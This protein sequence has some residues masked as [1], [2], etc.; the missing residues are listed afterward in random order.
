M[1]TTKAALIALTTARE[2]VIARL[3]DA[4]AAD[5]LDLDEFER[6]L[7]LAHRAEDVAA[8]DALVADL[9][10]P[11]PAAAPGGA[12]QAL[13]PAAP[14][15]GALVPAA[16]VRP[17]QKMLALLGSVERRGPWRVARDLT[18]RSWM[19]SVVLDFREAELGPG[20]TCVHIAA[21]MASVELIVP[22]WLS[23]EVEGT[24]I[25]GEFEH[26]ERSPRA[27]DPDAPLVRI[28]GYTVMG[29]VEIETRLPGESRGEARRR[30]KRERKL[31]EKERRKQLE[32]RG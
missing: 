13:V 24:S 10:Q 4:F 26:L 32:G 17:R 11:A 12:G 22:P 18:V 30:A 21:I 9:A 16:Q 14:A 29:A 15:H 2:R 1:A 20:V 5:D 7:N 6:R 19:G 23:V 8:L 28:T 25:M 31:A 3:S 27:P